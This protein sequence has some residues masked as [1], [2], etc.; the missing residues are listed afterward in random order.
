MASHGRHAHRG[1]GDTEHAT[2]LSALWSSQALTFP[3]LPED[4]PTEIKKDTSS[5]DDLKHVYSIYHASR[6]LNFQL[7][8]ER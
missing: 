4:A 5:V 1:S 7:L 3:R 6:R 2:A 8:V